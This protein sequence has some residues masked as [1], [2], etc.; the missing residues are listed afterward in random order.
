[1]TELPRR[2]RV[3]VVGGGIV[4][5]S[6]AR[7]LAGLGE[8]DVLL[9]E[10]EPMLGSRASAASAGGLRQQFPAEHDVLMAMEGVRQI[11]R[12]AEDTGHDPEFRSHGYLMLA[13]R[14]SRRQAYEAGAALQRR[15][16]LP[17]ETLSPAE[18]AKRWALLRT[19]DV[20]GAVFC[21]ADGICDPHAVVQGFAA[22]ARARGVRIATGVEVT[23]LLPDGPAVRGVATDHGDVR[24]EFVVNAGGAWAARLA[25][26]AGIALPLRPCKRQIFSTRPVPLPSDLPLVLD[27][28]RR[29]Y[30]RPESGG[31]ILSAAEVEEVADLE[32]VLDWS[33]V[34]DLVERAVHRCPALAEAS[35]ARGWAGLR[36]LT[37]DDS[38]ILGEVPGRP[39]LVLAVGLGGHG[40]TQGPAV[41]LAVAELIIRGKSSSLPLAPFHVGRFSDP[42]HSIV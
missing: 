10:R 6:V 34:P 19:S 8:T 35:I 31:A 16:G 36:T 11:R 12:L 3:V 28:D 24:S 27:L 33:G 41:G 13:C 21:G 42:P 20:L 39:G 5:V 30:F 7:H 40:I 14:K 29:F 38:A 1:M 15:L 18:I 37:P 2:V 32:P 23:G 26:T 4:G 17:V 22:H 9:L 25:A